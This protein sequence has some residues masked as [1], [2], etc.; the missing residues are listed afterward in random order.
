MWKSILFKEC[1]LIWPYPPFIEETPAFYLFQ[2]SQL[3]FLMA[4]AVFMIT[5][6]VSRTL[7]HSMPSVDKEGKLKL[8]AQS[9]IKCVLVVKY[10][11]LQAK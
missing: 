9:K 4:Q 8:K 7:C 6:F 2:H 3:C 11:I 10:L 1:C 5:Y